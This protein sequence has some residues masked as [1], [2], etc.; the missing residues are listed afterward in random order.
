MSLYSQPAA[1]GTA[2]LDDGESGLPFDDFDPVRAIRYSVPPWTRYRT[3]Y[4]DSSRDM[5]QTGPGETHGSLER[6][7]E[8]FRPDLV[9]FA[10]WLSRDR[11]VAEDIVQETMLRAWRARSEL[12]DPAAARPWLLTIARR[13]HARLHER[14]KLVTVDVDECVARQ[15]IA[16]AFTDPDPEIVDLRRAI[17]SLP[18]EYR[19]P[20]VMQV[21]G[22]FTSDEIASEL[23]L[24]VPAVLTRLFRARNKLKDLFASSTA[25]G[26]S[27]A[28]GAP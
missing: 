24:T 22:G 7:L 10:F 3:G 2:L 17:L 12:R 28:T 5:T 9:R 1:A 11:A 6:L 16:L 14:R 8:G 18:D 15:D 25:Q 20:L 23:G 21:L 27:A 26:V 19:E 13:E 4:G